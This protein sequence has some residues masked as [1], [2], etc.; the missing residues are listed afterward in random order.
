[1]VG[2]IVLKS[3]PIDTNNKGSKQNTIIDLATE[4][5]ERV[6]IISSP[7]YKFMLITVKSMTI[8]YGRS[9]IK[10]PKNLPNT[11][12]YLFIGLANIESIVP[13]SI[14][15]EMALTLVNTAKK[16]TIKLVTY[17]PKDIK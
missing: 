16:A 10:I 17:I 9:T 4:N 11:I 3:T 15:P 1:M 5:I 6:T 13:C 8:A 12:E 14:S 2:N 7:K